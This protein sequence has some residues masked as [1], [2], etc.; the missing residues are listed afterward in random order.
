MEQSDKEFDVVV[1]IEASS[2]S[3]ASKIADDIFEGH[4][5]KYASNRFEER[6]RVIS[7]TEVK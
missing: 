5:T 7:V 1:R 6:S 3:E 4:V 2:I